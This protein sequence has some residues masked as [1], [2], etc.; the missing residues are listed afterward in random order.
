M[1]EKLQVT[2]RP[3]RIKVDCSTKNLK[4]Q[5]AWTDVSQVLKDKLPTQ[6]NAGIL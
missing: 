5:V 6:I 4:H 1:K 2:H 3:I